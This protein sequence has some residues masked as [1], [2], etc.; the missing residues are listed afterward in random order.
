MR[1]LE[2]MESTDLS[3]WAQIAVNIG[4]GLGAAVVVVI[5]YLRARSPT[6][7]NAST[8]QVHVAGAIV[9][10]RALTPLVESLDNLTA[11]INRRVEQWEQREQNEKAREQERV[12]DELREQVSM[13]LK[14]VGDYDRTK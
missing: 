7:T 4:I 11:S 10:N 3:S 14:K 13:L 9:D 1:Q 5:G 2:T 6:G 8:S 12:I